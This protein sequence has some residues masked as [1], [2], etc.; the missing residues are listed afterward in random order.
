MKISKQNSRSFDYK[1]IIIF[2]PELSVSS[3]FIASLI[4]D[5]ILIIYQIILI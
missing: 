3:K 1:E 5:W 2:L 4:I